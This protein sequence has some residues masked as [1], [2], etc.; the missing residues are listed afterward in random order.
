MRLVE[1][2]LLAQHI[3][4]PHHTARPQHGT[5][6][7]SASIRQRRHRQFHLVVIRV[8]SKG[9]IASSVRSIHANIE[10]ILMIRI[11]RRTRVVICRART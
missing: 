6:N 10:L 3:R 11:V 8:A 9:A 4:Q 2:G 7:Q 5:T 1:D